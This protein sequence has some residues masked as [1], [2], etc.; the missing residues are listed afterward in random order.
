[1]EGFG[2]SFDK[3]FEELERVLFVV[4][5]RIGADERSTKGI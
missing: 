4:S 5:F 3:L 1:M 2:G